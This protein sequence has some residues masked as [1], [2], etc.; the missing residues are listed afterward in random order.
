MNNEIE[1]LRQAIEQ[2]NWWVAL[3]LTTTIHK[4]LVTIVND[5]YGFEI[6]KEGELEKCYRKN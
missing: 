6:N 5:K 1:L 2:K 4:H 3:A